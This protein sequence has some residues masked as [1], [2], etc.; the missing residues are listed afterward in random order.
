MQTAETNTSWVVFTNNKPCAFFDFKP[1]E[2]DLALIT[3]QYKDFNPSV[4]RLETNPEVTA[5][6][7]SLVSKFIPKASLEELN[8]YDDMLCA[9]GSKLYA[10][11]FQENDAIITRSRKKS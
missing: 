4:L 3:D 8:V 9:V 1:S 10:S 11:D 6:I 5:V 7:E 2:V